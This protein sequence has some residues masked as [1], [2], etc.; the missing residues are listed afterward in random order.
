MKEPNQDIF[1][2][3][4][5]A[6]KKQFVYPLT[7]ALSVHN[8]TFWLDDAQIV[9]G[10]SVVGRIN[11]GLRGSQLALLCLSQN[12]LRRP[13][14]ESEMA[15]VLS[16]QNSNGAKRAL[17]LILNSKEEVLNHYPLI[18][19]MSYR[20]FTYGPDQLASEIAS[21]VERTTHDADEISITVEGVHTGK[22]CRLKA[23]RRASVKWLAKMAQSGMEA[24]DAFQ[25]GP[26]GV[27]HVR[28]V[29]VD[30]EVESKWLEMSRS[31]QRDVYALVESDD[32]P[33]QASDPRERLQTLGVRDGTV[34]HLYAIEDEDF[35]PPAAAFV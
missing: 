11:E 33:R 15:A 13:W 22:V 27:F 12:F 35:D 19:G 3:H 14:P 7:E 28:W 31:Q 16:I 5:S 10:D 4:A 17:P 18:A 32:G 21:M 1:I 23:P 9:W 30:V 6:D 34:F 24:Q 20:E 8:V 2:S 26:F 25:V 29:L